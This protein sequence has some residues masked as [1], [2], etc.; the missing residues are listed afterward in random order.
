VLNAALRQV[1]QWR[2]QGMA[3]RLAVNL[4][5]G[6]LTDPELPSVIDQSLKTW[7]GAA[8]ELT[9]EIAESAMIADAERSDAVLTRL[10]ALG[11]SLAL[12]DFGSGFTS[13][14]HL[15]RL[16]IGE[17]KIDRPYVARF[18]DD[19]GDAALVRSAIDIGHHFGMR[20]V[21]EGVE[22][23]AVR[24]ALARAGCDFMQGNLASPALPAGQLHEWWMRNAAA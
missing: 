8:K 13:L 4:S 7:G 12:D 21:A 23:A 17:I 11:V 1:S 24:D 20:V 19:P 9:L 6:M 16:P 3:P 18:L 5:I 2:A 22:T 15:R 14:A 10:T